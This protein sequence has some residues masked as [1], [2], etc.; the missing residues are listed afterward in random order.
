MFMKR[1]SHRVF[2]YP[3]RFYKPELDETEKRKKKLGFSRRHKQ[4][5]RKRS[6]AIWGI[7]LLIIIYLYLKFTRLI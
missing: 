7:L 4:I 3:A 6:P 2:D 1:P 5:R